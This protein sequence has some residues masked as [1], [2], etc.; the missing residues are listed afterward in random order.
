MRGDLAQ[1]LLAAPALLVTA[2]RGLE[3]GHP[4]AGSRLHLSDAL[5]DL[6]DP[7]RDLMV[8]YERKPSQ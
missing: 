1:H 2:A 3:T 8:R 6:F 5:A 7:A 4:D